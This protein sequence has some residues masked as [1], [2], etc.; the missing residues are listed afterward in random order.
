V[1]VLGDRLALGRADKGWSQKRTAAEIGVPESTW[2]DWERGKVRP[3]PEKLK[4]V[5]EKLGIPLAELSELLVLSAGEPLLAPLEDRVETLER[6][7]AN[8]KREL[9]KATA[10]LAEVTKL[11]NALLHAPSQAPAATGQ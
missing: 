3:R 2:N 11:R 7:V 4:Q 10:M 6:E 8:L 5:S 1:S 9:H